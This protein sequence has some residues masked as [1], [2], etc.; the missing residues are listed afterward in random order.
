MRLKICVGWPIRKWRINGAKNG[1][2]TIFSTILLDLVFARSIP[3]PGTMDLVERRRSSKI[4][5]VAICSRE[6]F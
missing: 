2:D 4:L 5:T 3:N 6:N 1:K